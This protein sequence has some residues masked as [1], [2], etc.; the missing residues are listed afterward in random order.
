MTDSATLDQLADRLRSA[1]AVTVMTGAGISA[2]SGVPTFRGTDGLWRNYSATDLATPE[3]FARDPRLVWQWYRWRRGIIGR[4]EP[5]PG[6]LALA[7]LQSRMRAFTLI[8]QNVDGLHQRAGST[9]VIELH[10]NIWRARCA[11]GCGVVTDAAGEAAGDEPAGDQDPAPVC[12]C[13]ALLRPD[14]VWFGEALDQSRI[15]LALRAAQDCQAFLVIGTSALVYPA[16]GL[17]RV[18]ASAGALVVEINVDDTPLTPH[19][20]LVLRAKAAEVLPAL[21][22]RV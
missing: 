1:H 21:E 20:G 11:S 8:T 14:V 22:S 9:R 19:A 4:A 18:A 5:N 16:A 17:P 15:D 7:R 3:A 13:G 2:E 12:S 6:H 10:G